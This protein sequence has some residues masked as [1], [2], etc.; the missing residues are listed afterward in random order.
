MSVRKKYFYLLFRHWGQGFLFLA[1][2]F[3]LFFLVRLGFNHINELFF[4]GFKGA[5]KV[6][7]VS[8]SSI[9]ITLAVLVFLTSCLMYLVTNN[10]KYVKK[11]I[12]LI[13]TMYV[14]TG[15]FGA[16]DLLSVQN[17]SIVSAKNTLIAG[18]TYLL[19]RR[20]VAIEDKRVFLDIF[21]AL[22]NIYEANGVEGLPNISEEWKPYLR[23]IRGNREKSEK[24]SLNDNFF[25]WGL[26]HESD[27]FRISFRLRYTPFQ[28]K[29]YELVSLGYPHTVIGSLGKA[30]KKEVK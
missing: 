13:I 15:L 1:F 26:R 23:N 14:W 7:Q 25:M 24:Q 2:L 6:N 21:P 9:V 17:S 22:K 20:Y 4:L 5:D 19:F 28:L 27:S 8:I 30:Y 18:F 16:I 12:G 11:G 10:K 29:I 3:Q